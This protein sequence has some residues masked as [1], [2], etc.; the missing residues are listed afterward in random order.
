MRSK[1]LVDQLFERIRDA[2]EDPGDLLEALGVSYGELLILL[3]D[4]SLL[5]EEALP[6]I[7]SDGEQSDGGNIDNEYI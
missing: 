2:Y 7:Y 6:F 5:N 3:Y 4:W 1:V